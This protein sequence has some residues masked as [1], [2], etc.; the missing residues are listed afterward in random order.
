MLNLSY[1]RRGMG[2]ASTDN[3]DLNALYSTQVAN[4]Q[5]NEDVGV[6]PIVYG[7]STN[8]TGTPLLLGSSTIS[9]AANTLSNNSTLVVALCAIL[10]VMIAM[11]KK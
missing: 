11:G 5:L 6:G 8:M 7:G 4:Q 2:D 10:G 9:Q 1:F 3:A